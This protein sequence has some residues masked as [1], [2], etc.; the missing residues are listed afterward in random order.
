MENEMRVLEI[1]KEQVEKEEDSCVKQK[2][3][4]KLY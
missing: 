3:E 2:L 4:D 1:G